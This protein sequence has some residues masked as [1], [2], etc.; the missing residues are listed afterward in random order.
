[1]CSIIAASPSRKSAKRRSGD[2]AT[3]VP[4]A[5][6]AERAPVETQLHFP[7]SMIFHVIGGVKRPP[8]QRSRSIRVSGRD[9]IAFS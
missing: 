1:M 4:V 7:L 3:A 5:A 6:G 2:V 8:I 9:T